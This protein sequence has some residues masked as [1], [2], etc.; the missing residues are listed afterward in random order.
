MTCVMTSDSD[1]GWPLPVSSTLSANGSQRR[2]DTEANTLGG[3]V[4]KQFTR[5]NFL[6]ATAGAGRLRRPTWLGLRFRFVRRFPRAA[7]MHVKDWRK[8]KPKPT[9]TAS[10]C[11]SFL[12]SGK[13]SFYQTTEMEDG[14]TCR[15]DGVVG[16]EPIKSGSDWCLPA[17][18]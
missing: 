10:I 4:N 18:N 11:F 5:D 17:W 6:V 12:F 2:F 16:T 13:R 15:E 1:C 14:V 7:G 3:E 9:I 8:K